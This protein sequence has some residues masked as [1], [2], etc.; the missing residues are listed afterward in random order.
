[1]SGYDIIGDDDYGSVGYDFIGDEDDDGF[2]EL[3]VGSDDDESLLQ[4]LSI[5]GMGGSDIVGAAAKARAKK[6][7]KRKISNAARQLALRN[8][9]M[10][11]R[12]EPR[13]RRRL[14][15]GFV[16]TQVLA[17]ATVEVPSSP[18]NLFRTERLVIPSDNAFDFGIRD[19][20][21]GNVSQLV[22]S[23]ELPAAMFTEVAIDTNIHFD[24]AEVGNQVSIS[25]VNKTAG[26]LT[27]TGGL[28][29]TSAK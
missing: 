15:I 24:T 22:Q 1:M 29:G 20:K 16:P 11:V 14:P 28:I 4:S 17:A 18:Q 5:A 12:R 2:D 19:I 10:V 13:L 3:L 23:G 7:V 6:A 8:A 25:V 21:V 27:F 26:T 9:G